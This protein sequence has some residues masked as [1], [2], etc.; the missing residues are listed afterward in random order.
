MQ[1]AVVLRGVEG[2]REVRG[3]SV[4]S[5]GRSRPGGARRF[6]SEDSLYVADTPGLI[7][8]GRHDM[9]SCHNVWGG[10]DDLCAKTN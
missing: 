8:K 7:P 10:G 5:R 1:E 2:S 3:A 4:R 6:C 9:S